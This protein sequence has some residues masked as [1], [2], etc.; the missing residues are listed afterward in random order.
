MTKGKKL[1]AACAAL[2]LSFGAAAVPANA[3]DMGMMHHRHMM[4]EHM[5][6]HHDRMMMHRD[7]MMMHRGMMRHHMMMHHR[8]MHRMM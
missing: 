8:M 4:R 6:M 7:H 2:A 5:M 3:Q 1:L